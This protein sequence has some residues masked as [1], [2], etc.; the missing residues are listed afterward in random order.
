LAEALLKYTFAASLKE[1][2]EDLAFFD[3]RIKKGLVAKLEGM[4]GSDG[5][6]RGDGSF[7]DA[8]SAAGYSAAESSTVSKASK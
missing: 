1:R 4:V 3:Q 8:A 7:D 2:E 5:L 6:R